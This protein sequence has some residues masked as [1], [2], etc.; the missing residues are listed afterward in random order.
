MKLEKRLAELQQDYDQN[1]VEL[2]NVSTKYTQ[3]K[4][5]KVNKEDAVKDLETTVV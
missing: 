5:K 4:E 2:E 1:K 3:I